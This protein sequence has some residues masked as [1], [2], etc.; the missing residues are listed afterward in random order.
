M[1]TEEP[2][3]RLS[4]GSVVLECILEFVQE[5]TLSGHAVTIDSDGHVAVTPNDVY[6]DLLF[7]LDSN[8]RDVA[9][10]LETGAAIVTVH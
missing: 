2:T 4:D 1:I 3:T 7:I 6:P 10:I 8:R 9:A 5:L